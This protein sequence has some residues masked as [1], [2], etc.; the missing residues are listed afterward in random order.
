MAEHHCVD[1]QQHSYPSSSHACN[2]LDDPS[3]STFVNIP[4]DTQ[5]K[6][7]ACIDGSLQSSELEAS[8]LP[9]VT[10]IKSTSNC[11]S[12]GSQANERELRESQPLLKRMD[13]DHISINNVFP[14]DPEF[15]ELVREA[16][17]A[18]EAEIFPERITRGSS[19]S[20]FVLNCS[21]VRINTDDDIYYFF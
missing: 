19:G 9:D 16:E 5:M 1:V 12:L 8:T 4:H 2:N 7:F 14:D 17:N 15:T 6:P 11:N 20:Y 10:Y 3:P 21:K 18:I 13:P